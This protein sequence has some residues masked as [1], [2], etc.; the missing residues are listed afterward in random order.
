MALERPVARGK[1][2][3]VCGENIAL[4][5]TQ[6]SV[7][8]TPPRMRR[9]LRRSYS[10]AGNRRNTSAYAEK[11][12]GTYLNFIFTLERQVNNVFYLK[13]PSHQHQKT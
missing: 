3:R 9:K 4:P 7:R 12:Y 1:H 13:M 2:L 5:L 10:I 8:E 11:T 6:T